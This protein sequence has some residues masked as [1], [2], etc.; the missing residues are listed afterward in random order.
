MQTTLSKTTK[1]RKSCDFLLRGNRQRPILPGRVQPSTFGTGELNY[2]VRYGNRWDLSVITTGRFS[3]RVSFFPF[4]S[5]SFLLSF[6]SARF[7]L[8]FRSFPNPQPA[9]TCFSSLASLPSLSGSPFHLLRSSLF[10]FFSVPFRSASFLSDLC[11]PFSPFA[12]RF[13]AFPFAFAPFFRLFPALHFSVHPDNC[14]NRIQYFRP[15]HN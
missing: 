6:R 4:R 7:P 2:C 10:R 3:G 5:A 9:V 13:P 15:F 12:F 14:T 1:K 8:R 11:F